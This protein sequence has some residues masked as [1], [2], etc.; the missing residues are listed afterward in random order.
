MYLF[1]ET[2]KTLHVWLLLCLCILWLAF[3]V[4]MFHVLNTQ[5]V[6][7]IPYGNKPLADIALILIIIFGNIL[8]S[9]ALYFIIKLKLC[10]KIYK[11]SIEFS[12]PPIINNRI[13]YFS[14]IDYMWVKK[15]SPLIESKGWNYKTLYK[16][17]SYNIWGKWGIQIITKDG[18]KILLGIINKN[19]AIKILT[20]LRYNIPS[21][22][23]K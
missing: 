17:K 1:N 2:Q 9:I 22:K 15:Y 21:P 6:K 23:Y 11:D 4:F 13:I 8:F 14:N 20:E 16:S 3:L 7:G 18:N 12:F 5:T 10:I 19:M